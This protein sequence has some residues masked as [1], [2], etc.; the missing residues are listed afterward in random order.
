[1][2]QEIKE[3]DL[4]ASSKEVG[5]VLIDA[6]RPVQENTSLSEGDGV[7]R[8]F[9]PFIE[10]GEVQTPQVAMER[11]ERVF[12]SACYIKVTCKEERIRLLD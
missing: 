6:H 3:V 9:A 4:W 8:E 1:L 7:R 11:T 12:P 5:F 10:F 2:R